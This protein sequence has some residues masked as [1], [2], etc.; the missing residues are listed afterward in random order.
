MAQRQPAKL[1]KVPHKAQPEKKKAQAHKP[2]NPNSGVVAGPNKALI[3]DCPSCGARIS[4]RAHQCPKC[5]STPYDHC[6]IC[7]A[8]ILA[9]TTPC[10]ECGD[11]SPFDTEAA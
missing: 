4:K 10:P 6:Q 7:A 11:P 5:G 1:K 2:A 3:M 9:N 8:R